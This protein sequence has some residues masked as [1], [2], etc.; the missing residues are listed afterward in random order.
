MAFAGIDKPGATHLFRHACATHMLENGTDIRYIQALL[1]HANLATT[2]IYTHVSI[3]KLQKPILPRP[4]ISPKPGFPERLLPDNFPQLP[5]EGTQ[6][7]GEGW[8][9]RGPDA[10]G[11]P[12]GGWYNPEKDWTLH[13]DLK[14]AEPIGPHWDSVDENNAHYRLTPQTPVVPGHI[15]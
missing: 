5:K 7:P 15:Y 14:H 11:G 12:R 6:C 13:P 10:P 9:W 1:G 8:E 2:E 4:L 3:E